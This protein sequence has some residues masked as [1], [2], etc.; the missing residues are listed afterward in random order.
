MPC[1]NN[2]YICK[3]NSKEVAGVAEQDR[4]VL[5]Y[6]VCFSVYLMLISDKLAVWVWVSIEQ[7]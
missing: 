2:V 4:R 5:V 3:A 7:L 1:T 6:G